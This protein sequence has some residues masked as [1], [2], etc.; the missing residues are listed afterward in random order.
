M[1]SKVKILSGFMTT[2]L[3]L[4]LAFCLDLWAMQEGGRYFWLEVGLAIL[5]FLV[6]AFIGIYVRMRKRAGNGFGVGIL[7][8]YFIGL[9]FY[10]VVFC[11]FNT[12]GS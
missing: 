1:I 3:F 6:P 7:T 12:H 4:V 9:I 10:I 5:L 8:G 11:Y 2:I